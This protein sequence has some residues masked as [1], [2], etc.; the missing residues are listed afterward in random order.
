MADRPDIE[1]TVTPFRHPNPSLVR[2][3]GIVHAGSFTDYDESH[4]RWRDNPGAVK[5][6]TDQLRH[7]IATELMEW[8][9]EYAPSHLEYYFQERYRS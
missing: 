3:Q 7:G 1:V 2:V 6:V 9:K 5:A 4:G 8:L